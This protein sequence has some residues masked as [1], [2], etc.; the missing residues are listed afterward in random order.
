ME[1]RNVDH[2][3]AQVRADSRDDLIIDGLGPDAS[4]SADTLLVPS[5]RQGGRDGTIGSR[6]PRHLETTWFII[7]RPS[8]GQRAVTRRAPR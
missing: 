5:R 4:G 3:A 8:T 1:W 6:R 2:N 7:T